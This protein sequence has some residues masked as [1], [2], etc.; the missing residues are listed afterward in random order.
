MIWKINL[1]GNKSKR[2]VYP[3]LFIGVLVL[4]AGCVQGQ[5][6]TGN[7][8]SD[9]PAGGEQ[10]VFIELGSVNCIPCKQMQPIINAIENEYEGKVKVV[11]YD[12]WTKDG[13]QY[14]DKYKIRLIPTQVFLDKQGNEIFRHEGFF[15]KKEIEKIFENA[16]VKK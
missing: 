13:K 15:P 1:T 6:V 7:N 14:A 4:L 9:L 10:V 16:G 8:N 3:V 12:V 11:F 2:T 5:D